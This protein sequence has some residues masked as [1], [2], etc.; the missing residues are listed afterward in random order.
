M[1]FMNIDALFDKLVV[2]LEASGVA[3]QGHDSESSDRATERVLT[4]EGTAFARLRG[5]TMAFFMPPGTP[6]L[7]DALA[8]ETSRPAGDGEWV[9]V[10]AQDVSQWPI[11]AEQSL[12]GLRR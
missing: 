11:L 9:E 7:P 4:Y 3:E 6:S 5:E 12:A 2:D 10:P 1:P 8:L